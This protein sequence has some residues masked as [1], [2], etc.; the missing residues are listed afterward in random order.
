M[1]NLIIEDWRKRL[2]LLSSSS[3][4]KARLERK[5]RSKRF[6]RHW[7][8]RNSNLATKMKLKRSSTRSSRSRSRS[9]KKP[10]KSL[11]KREKKV[12]QSR[13]RLKMKIKRKTR[14]NQNRWQLKSQKERRKIKKRK[15]LLKNWI[16]ELSRLLL[17]FLHNFF[18]RFWMLELCSLSGLW[19]GKTS[20]QRKLNSKS[21]TKRTSWSFWKGEFSLLT[22][23][24]K[25]RK[26]SQSKNLSQKMCYTALRKR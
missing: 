26:R 23:L 3:C 2:E 16:E 22:E 21:S 24:R 4:S 6:K 25:W 17:F 10:K 20:L 13:R 14:R 5:P 1:K 9:K 15:R 19:L 7:L 18:L 12:L 11:V 8:K